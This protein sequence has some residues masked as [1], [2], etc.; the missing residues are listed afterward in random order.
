MSKLTREE[1]DR[2]ADH[3]KGTC[4]S[5]LQA[6]EYLEYEVD[7][8]VAEDQL[9]DVNV[10]CCKGCGWWDESCELEKEKNGETGYCRQCIPDIEE[11]E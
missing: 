10:E 6:L 8:S 7:E 5:V 4:K 11:D 3:I 9:L 1:L 2:L